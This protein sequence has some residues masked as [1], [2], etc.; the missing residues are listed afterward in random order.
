MKRFLSDPD[1]GRLKEQLFSAHEDVSQGQSVPIHDPD[2]SYIDL[3]RHADDVSTE[4][5]NTKLQERNGKLE[6]APGRMVGM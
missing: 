4:G 2:R 6:E 3:E 5:L 1:R